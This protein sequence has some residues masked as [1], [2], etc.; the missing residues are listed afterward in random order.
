MLPF[1]RKQRLLLSAHP[2]AGDGGRVDFLCSAD[3]SPMG[4]PID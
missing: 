2:K 3:E 1:G 4:G